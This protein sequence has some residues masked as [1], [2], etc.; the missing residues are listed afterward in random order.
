MTIDFNG[1]AVSLVIIA[2]IARCEFDDRREHEIKMD[3]IRYEREA[4]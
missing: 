1:I 4:R 3:N 2:F